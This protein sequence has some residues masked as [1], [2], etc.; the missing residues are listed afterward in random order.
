MLLRFLF[1]LLMNHFDVS[2]AFVKMNAAMLAVGV[3]GFVAFRL[4]MN[5]RERQRRVAAALLIW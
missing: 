2:L 1:C 5:G 4:F 3:F